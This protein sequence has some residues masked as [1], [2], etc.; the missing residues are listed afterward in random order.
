MNNISLKGKSFLTLK[1]F[2]KEEIRY[3][4]TL[5]SYLKTK[6]KVGIKGDLLQGKNIALLFEKTSTRTRCSFEVAAMMKEHM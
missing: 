3:L 2:T 5:S 1:D 6:K 4:L